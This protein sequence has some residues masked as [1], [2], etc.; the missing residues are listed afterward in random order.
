MDSKRPTVTVFGSCRV[1]APCSMLHKSDAV[2]LFQSNIFG[3]VHY[4]SEVIQQFELITGARPVPPRLRPFLN[5]PDHWRAPEHRDVASFHEQFRATD[6][7]VVEVSSIRKLLFKAFYLQINRTREL[8]VSDDDTQKNWW[9]PLV[10]HGENRSAEYK[11]STASDL[12]KEIVL[13]LQ[14]KD[15]TFD[16]IL[17]DM[18]R[19]KRFLRK[20][21]LFVS[22]FN[23]DYQGKSVPQR[24]LIV[25]AIEA[26]AVEAGCHAFDPTPDVLDAG[27]E[28]SIKDLGHYKPEFEAR[29]AER[30][31]EEIRLALGPASAIRIGARGRGDGPADARPLSLRSMVRDGGTDVGIADRA[32]VR[33]FA[34]PFQKKLHIRPNPRAADMVRLLADGGA[35]SCVE[36][37]CG[38]GL[39]AA[40][41]ARHPLFEGVG[42]TT[43][44]YPYLLHA[45][46]RSAPNHA[47][48]PLS[49]EWHRRLL[50][51][52]GRRR[53][54]HL[55]SILERVPDPLGVLR[56]AGE[57][58]GPSSAVVVSL[59]P[60]S[61]GPRVLPDD[62][63]QQWTEEEF[64]RFAAGAGFRV[65]AQAASK[66]WWCFLL[67]SSEAAPA[68]FAG[69]TLRVGGHEYR[70]D[71]GGD[72]V[73]RIASGPSDALPK[74]EA[75][76][77]DDLD[78]LDHLNAYVSTAARVYPRE[79]RKS[80]NEVALKRIEGSVLARKPL[81][82]VR[83]S[84][85]EIRALAYPAQY[86][87]VWLNRSLKVCFGTEIDVG[88]YGAFLGDLEA[89]VRSCDVLGVPDPHS[90]D[91]QHATNAVLLDEEGITVGKDK[92]FG[93]LHFSLLD[94]GVLDRLISASA[95]V[96]LITS[97]DILDGFRRKY[98]RPDARLIQIPGEARW[99]G[100]GPRRHVPD[101]Y[102]EIVR[103]LR[104]REP[105]ELFLV[106]AGLASKRY[107]QLARDQGGVAID[108]GSV[109]DLWGG[110]ATRSG[111]EA[112][113]KLMSLV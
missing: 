101:A 14:V 17:F 8:L 113:T 49:H 51:D 98:G 6:V 104:V 20:P 78:N 87:P 36:V 79:A 30:L 10:R 81:S 76:E 46:R 13:N 31:E 74:L 63:Y 84:H 95:C 59:R 3:F 77:I 37:G 67:Q 93:D 58:A 107:C 53:I 50:D 26:V 4:T 40:R 108:I 38:L 32:R 80:A 85:A 7:F 23:T 88:D 39:H 16:D 99:M 100:S 82:A 56:A 92:F 96:A 73:P 61:A 21:V 15:Q 62:C 57:L 66:D 105:G 47:F 65:A 18:K 89:A 64:T 90:R 43:V 45:L 19:I 91:L 70:F 72:G 12:Q 29:I 52:G 69:G 2:E 55:S 106:G 41:F 54:V 11:L 44:E 28:S 97:R 24:K 94:R 22:H 25:D 75:F 68:P 5:I 103:D 109:F 27:L 1:H 9:T 83:V 48:R 112:K 102:D 111:F 42:F 86:P 110:A 71:L 34:S 33:H 60:P 35:A